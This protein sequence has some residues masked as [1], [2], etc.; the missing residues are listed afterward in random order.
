MKCDRTC[1]YIIDV[2]NRGRS[3]EDDV[4]R[5]LDGAQHFQRLWLDVEDGD[6]AVAVY[7]PDRLQFRTVHRVFVRSCRPKTQIDGSTTTQLC[8]FT[9]IKVNSQV[10][11]WLQLFEINFKSPSQ[12]SK[13]S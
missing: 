10:Q 4:G 7:P 2:L 6:L 12:Q 11:L 3:D 5:V 8:Y 13:E 1:S 9:L